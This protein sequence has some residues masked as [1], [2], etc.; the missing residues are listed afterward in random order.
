MLAGMIADFVYDATAGNWKLLNPNV[1]ASEGVLG[2]IRFGDFEGDVVP[3]GW[4]F[5]VAGTIGDALSGAT[6]R[7]NADTQN[8]YVYWWTKYS[9]PSGNTIMTISGVLGASAID[10]YN[11]HKPMRLP[12]LG[13][14]ATAVGG[15]LNTTP[16]FSR[17]AGEVEGSTTHSINVNEMPSHNHT[18]TEF[19]DS[20]APAGQ[21]FEPKSEGFGKAFSGVST[22]LKGGNVPF[23]HIGPVAYMNAMIKL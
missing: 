13:A 9:Q 18:Y 1:A 17:Y 3:A 22:S 21:G 10:D 6:V 23:E 20:Q 16:T 19:V 7:A 8:L 2:E 12:E 11:A 14:R 4:F 15:T 5:W